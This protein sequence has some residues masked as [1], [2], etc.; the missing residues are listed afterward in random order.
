MS[1]VWLCVDEDSPQLDAYVAGIVREAVEQVERNIGVD[2]PRRA[3]IL[4]QTA[5]LVET[6]CRDAIASARA[7][8]AIERARNLH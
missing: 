3:E 6:K 4:A 5:R 8:A 2:H 1:D 7:N